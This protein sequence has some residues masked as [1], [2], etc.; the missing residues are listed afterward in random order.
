MGLRRARFRRACAVRARLDFRQLPRRFGRHRLELRLL[1]RQPLALDDRLARRRLAPRDLVA[2]LRRAPVALHRLRARR[3]HLQPQAV[4][5][6]LRVVEGGLRLRERILR[7]R[8]PLFQELRLLRERLHLQRDFLQLEPG[9]RDLASVALGEH[10]VFRDAL[11]V[12]ADDLVRAPVRAVCR[13]LFLRELLQALF[14]LVDFAVQLLL[15][16]FGGGHRLARLRNRRLDF[17]AVRRVLF[18]R[19]VEL[20]DLLLGHVDV[21]PAQLVAEFLVLL[22]L[23][24]L[25]L[26]RAD[27][28]LHL[29]QDVRLAQ[30]VLLGLLDLPQRLLAVRLELGDARRLL[31]HRA[32]VLGLGREDR[33][34]LALRHHRI[35]ACADARA[36]EEVL[37]VLQA[38]RLLVDEVF[39]RAVAVDAPRDRDLVVVGAELLFAVGEGD[40]DFRE[41]ERLARVGAVE[42]DVHQL[43]ASE[44]GR[45]L[46]AQHPADGVG[47]VRFSAPVGPDD[48]DQPRF[49]RQPRL[50]REA[51]EPDDV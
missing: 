27:L 3:L 12:D 47:N 25:P 38:A 19:L 4:D 22:R 18:Q 11:G 5:F 49:K 30:Q 40:G 10:P 34:D 23:A 48:G 26:Q 45:A 9:V 42:D 6:A 28:P 36:H 21:E 33:V 44:R 41:A 16:G 43:R 51:L 20:V 31:E 39:A 1:R 29:P 50:V 13:R 7:G 15:R 35:R 17:L 46:F 2:D 8:E 37:D 14:Q 32:A 24:D